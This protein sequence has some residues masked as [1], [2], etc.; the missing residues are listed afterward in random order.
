MGAY[1]SKNEITV[2]HNGG[3]GKPKSPSDKSHFSSDS[4]KCPPGF[5]PQ[6]VPD[7]FKVLGPASQ[8]SYLK[9]LYGI[10]PK[11]LMSFY[12]C[13]FSFG[14]NTSIVLVHE[15]GLVL[16]INRGLTKVGTCYWGTIMAP[17]SPMKVLKDIPECV[18]LDEDYTLALKNCSSGHPY[19]RTVNAWRTA[20]R[21]SLIR[22]NAK[23]LER[24][25]TQ[26]GV[27]PVDTD[28]DDLCESL[29]TSGLSTQSDE[30]K[31]L[32][33][34]TSKFT[35]KA[36]KAKTLL[37]QY[38]KEADETAA[39]IH[40][41]EKHLTL[42]GKPFL[43]REEILSTPE[44]KVQTH[45]PREILKGKRRSTKLEAKLEAEAEAEAEANQMDE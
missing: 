34:K 45:L 36:E 8:H 28:V 31:R 14:T 38:T 1:L 43:S 41:H 29:K 33:S 25:A 21:E 15:S 35:D 26:I 30:Y 40:E 39:R 11:I 20:Q 9:T 4:T 27:I 18:A 24:I 2:I 5:T 22:N 7:T 44:I 13:E 23:Q 16:F 42:L 3:N 17:D 32:Q 6:Q 37:Y 12:I 10:N 19:E